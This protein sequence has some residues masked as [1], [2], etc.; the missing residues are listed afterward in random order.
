MINIKPYLFI[1]LTFGLY[2]LLDPASSQLVYSA[3]IYVRSLLL[4]VLLCCAVWFAEQEEGTL[5]VPSPIHFTCIPSYTLPLA[6][7]SSHYLITLF[8]PSLFIFSFY[9]PN[10]FYHWPLRSSFPSN[11]ESLRSQPLVPSHYL[12]LRI[13]SSLLHPLPSP[14]LLLQQYLPSF[15]PGLSR[16]S[17]AQANLD[18]LAIQSNRHLP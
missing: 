4:P 2:N 15:F 18:D 12:A 8:S 13:Y 10:F 7:P 9:H 5:S 14:P 1:S 6:L 11:G 17:N 16:K 3:R